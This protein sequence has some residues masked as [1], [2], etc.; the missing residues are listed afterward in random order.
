M[1]NYFSLRLNIEKGSLICH[2]LIYFYLIEWLY[3][4]KVGA[5]MVLST[6]SMQSNNFSVHLVYNI[7]Y[8]PLSN[9]RGYE[10]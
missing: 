10:T 9:I 8:H 2:K 1:S 3:S 5:N 7:F 4:N 6:L